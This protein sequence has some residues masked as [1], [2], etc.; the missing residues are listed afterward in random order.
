MS[1]LATPGSPSRVHRLSLAVFVLIVG[2]LLMTLSAKLQIPF[3]PVPMTLH[4]LAVMAFAV[5]L[6]PR[7]ASAVFLA[8]LSA[9][10]AG[11]P[12]FSGTP[13]RGLGL[14]YMMGPTG[15]YLLGYLLASGVTGVLARGRGMLGHLGAMLAG[16]SVVYA[17]GLGWL[18]FYVPADSI[19]ALGLTPFL[20]GDLVKVAVV[21]VG[22]QLMSPLA[23]R[24]SRKWL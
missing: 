12:V 8:Y 7:L 10:A 24:L 1:A 20:A 22:A 17:M 3:W 9:G 11:L 13:E 2:P 14:A 15:G 21:A 16:L 18:A 5:A 23:C 6:G 19:L 4:T